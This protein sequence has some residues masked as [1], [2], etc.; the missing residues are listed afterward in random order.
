MALRSASA[1]GKAARHAG[2]QRWSGSRRQCKFRIKIFTTA[3]LFYLVR[4]VERFDGER[5]A[6]HLGDRVQVTGRFSYAPD[7]G[8]VIEAEAVEVSGNR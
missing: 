7:A 4:Q 6:P 3:R 2:R 8:R 1:A 5:I